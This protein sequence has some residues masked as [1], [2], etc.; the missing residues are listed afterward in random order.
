MSTAPSFAMTVPIGAWHPF[1]PDCLASLAAQDVALQVALLDASGDDRVRKTADE[2][3][4]L[5][6]HRYH[7]PDDGQADAIASGW[8]RAEGSVLGWLN[9]DDALYPGALEK[10]SERMMQAD[11]PSVVYGHSTIIDTKRRLVGW[12]YG[13][14]QPSERLRHTAGISQPSCFFTREAL[15]AVGGLDRSLHYTMDWDLFLRLYR[16]GVPF[17]FL[18]EALSR[19]LWETGTKTASFTTRRREEIER[20]DRLYPGPD[21]YRSSLRGFRVQN[22]IDQ[23]PGFIRERLSRL[24]MKGSTPIHGLRADGFIAKKAAFP[25]MHWGAEA[26]NEV[27]IEMASLSASGVEVSF[28]GQT[29]KT[30]VRG[31][32]ISAELPSPLHAGE[33]ADLVLTL[34]SGSGYFRALSLKPGA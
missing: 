3:G 10:V 4:D 13:V 34:G 5:L 30:E 25:L 33:K 15:D 29:A 14:E 7:G 24:L 9:A 16:S 31:R 17:A 19:I 1:L 2:F 23:A 26:K 28:A 32:M 20:I 21:G 27:V 18:D 6:T 22:V 8:E 11:R 12:Q